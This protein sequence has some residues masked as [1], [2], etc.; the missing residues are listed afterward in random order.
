MSDRNFPLIELTRLVKRY[1]DKAAVDDVSLEVFSGEIFGFLGPNGAGKTTN[2]Q[3]DRGSLAA[4]LGYCACG[5]YDAFKDPLQ[6]ICHR[7]C[8]R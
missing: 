5:G 8:A 1:G 7:V 4:H 6:P 3:N 2:D